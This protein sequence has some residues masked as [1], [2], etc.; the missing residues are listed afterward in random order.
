M[1]TPEQPMTSVYTRAIKAGHE[2][3]FEAWF[4]ALSQTAHT[5]DGHLGSGII[6]LPNTDHPEY[7][8][9]FRF[10]SEAHL[11]AWETAPVRAAAM[12]QIEHALR[13]TANREVISGF[14]YWFVMPNRPT[15]PRWKMTIVTYLAITPLAYTLT[16]LIAFPL[17]GL[18]LHDFAAS[19]ISSVV[20]TAIMSYALMPFMIRLFERWLYPS[21]ATPTTATSL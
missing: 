6:K 21:A 18:G 2:A 20:I 12:Q 4:K 3:A 10:D 8:T 17:M 9:L 14:E 5:F 19:A 16:H 7:V 1:N 11:R 15:P 13:G